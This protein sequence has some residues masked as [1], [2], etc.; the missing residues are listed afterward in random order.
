MHN[1]YHIKYIPKKIKKI[2]YLRYKY[3]TILH[4]KLKYV[5]FVTHIIFLEKNISIV[6]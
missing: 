6:I 4:T 1:Y 5:S 2:V 3:N